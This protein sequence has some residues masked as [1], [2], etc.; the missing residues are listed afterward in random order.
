MSVFISHNKT[1]KS[2]AREIG[3]F[4]SQKELMFGLMNG[5][6]QLGIELQKK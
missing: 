3:I 2:I 4:L 1:D 5:I 6:F